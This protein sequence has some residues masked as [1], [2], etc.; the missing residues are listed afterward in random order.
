MESVVP[1]PH[2]FQHRACRFFSSRPSIWT[3][4]APAIHWLRAP[5]GT[6][7]AGLC[8]T[9]TSEWAPHGPRLSICH[10]ALPWWRVVYLLDLWLCT[11]QTN[12]ADLHF[13]QTPANRAWTE[14]V[15]DPSVRWRCQ[16]S[17]MERCEK[18]KVA[19][20]AFGPRSWKAPKS[21]VTFI[22]VCSELQHNSTEIGQRSFQL[23][24]MSF[25]WSVVI[26]TAHHSAV[27]FRNLDSNPDLD[28]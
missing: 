18:L 26:T 15:R 22:Q 5:L 3:P 6:S 16:A 2:F 1:L 21:S 27:T 8:K 28:F 25:H 12:R 17:Q 13:Y 19:V 10:L 4:T 23:Q 7:D 14:F 20:R 11:I 9:V 24:N